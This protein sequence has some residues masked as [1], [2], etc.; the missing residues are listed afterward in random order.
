M[1]TCFVSRIICFVRLLFQLFERL[2][3]KSFQTNKIT[4]IFLTN[5]VYFIE[6]KRYVNY[7]IWTIYVNEKILFLT[8]VLIMR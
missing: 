8:H 1:Q 2:A 7:V 6:V 5:S 3:G 4:C